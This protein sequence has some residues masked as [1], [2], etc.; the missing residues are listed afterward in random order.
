MWFRLPRKA[1]EANKGAANRAS[2]RRLVRTGP[3]PGILAYRGD[4]PVGWCAVGPRDTYPVLDRSRNLRPIDDTPVWSVTCFFIRRDARRQGLSVGLL[5]AAGRLAAGR[6][7]QVLEGYPVEPK[8]PGAMPDA[9]AWTGLAA[10]FR[11]A[12]F[13]EVARRAPTRPIFRKRL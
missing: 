10:A 2:F 7:A 3:P 13:R 4:D 1:W 11:K 9:F 5:Q 8:T 6:G 12:G